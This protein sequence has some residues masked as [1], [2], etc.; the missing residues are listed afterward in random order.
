[1]TKKKDAEIIKLLKYNWRPKSIASYL[2][3]QDKDVWRVQKENNL[4]QK[5]NNFEDFYY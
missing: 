5:N 4:M 1:M 2:G 3:V